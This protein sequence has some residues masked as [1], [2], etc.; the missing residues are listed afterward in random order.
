MLDGDVE[1]SAVSRKL[2]AKAPGN[3]GFTDLAA[4][5]KERECPISATETEEHNSLQNTWARCL[6]T[7]A[8][9]P[10]IDRFRFIRA[11]SIHSG[12]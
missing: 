5:R 2:R 12:P 11:Q 7:A 4:C 3:R 8:S 6:D 1:C 9:V 10:R